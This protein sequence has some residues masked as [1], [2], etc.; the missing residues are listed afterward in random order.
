M[1]VVLGPVGVPNH[2]LQGVLLLVGLLLLGIPHLLQGLLLLGILSLQGI[3][4]Q[5]TLFVMI[6]TL[7]VMGLV[8]PQYVFLS[9][10]FYVFPLSCFCLCTTPVSLIYDNTLLDLF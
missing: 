8:P 1:V 10:P 9:R 3:L 4:P 6:W 2:L 7:W 5:E